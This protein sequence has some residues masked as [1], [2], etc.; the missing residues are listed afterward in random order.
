[1]WQYCQYLEIDWIWC[2]TEPERR[3]YHAYEITFQ[4][5]DA[6]MHLLNLINCYLRYFVLQFEFDYGIETAE[7]VA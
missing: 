6:N 5:D 7:K 3:L 1:M 4:P 2:H